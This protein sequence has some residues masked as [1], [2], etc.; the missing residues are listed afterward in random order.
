MVEEI[1]QG[2]GLGTERPII[3]VFASAQN[4]RFKFYW[5]RDTP[6]SNGM[7]SFAMDWGNP[8][9]L[10]MNPPFERLG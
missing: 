5:G 7:S 8:S 1:L 2:L 9:L 4:K 10:W 3:D 6:G